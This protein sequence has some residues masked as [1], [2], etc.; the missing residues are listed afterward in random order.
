MPT[1]LYMMGAFSGYR[2]VRDPFAFAPG[3]NA[4][5]ALSRSMGEAQVA[6]PFTPIDQGEEAAFM[7][8]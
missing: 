6:W 8:R 2:A 3:E 1:P 5:A 7:K 4:G